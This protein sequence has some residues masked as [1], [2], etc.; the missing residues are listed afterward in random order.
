MRTCIHTWRLLLFAEPSFS[1]SFHP[2]LSCLFI[3]SPVLPTPRKILHCGCCAVLEIH[4]EQGKRKS[5]KKRGEGLSRAKFSRQNK[6]S[7]RTFF[8]FSLFVSVGHT[9][10]DSLSFSRRLLP[11]ASSTYFTL[12]LS[13]LQR[14]R[15]QLH[16]QRRRAFEKNRCDDE[17][18]RSGYRRFLLLTRCTLRNPLRVYHR[19]STA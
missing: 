15:E 5:E 7:P 19:S 3:I 6:T 16:E 11:I 14:C 4:V 12:S 18:V 10:C 8:F 17:Q 13:R 9:L 2:L 1:F